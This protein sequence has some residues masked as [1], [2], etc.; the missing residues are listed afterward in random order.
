MT[1][2]IDEDGFRANVGIILCNDAG[3][4][5]LAGRAG[6]RGWQFPQGGIQPDED[7]EQAMFRELEEEVG[8]AHAD[9]SVLGTTVPWLRYR[10]PRRYLRRNSVP[11]CV[12]QK[13]IWFMLKLETDDQAVRF[14]KCDVPE[15]DRWRWVDYWQPVR[16]VI[17]F[18]RRVYSRALENL[19]PLLFA[20]G[21]PPK[22]R[23]L[24]SSSNGGRN[25]RNGRARHAASRRRKGKS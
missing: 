16:E 1:D 6:Q 22:P 2:H 15:F 7:P 5:L 17:Y 20:D 21:L 18:K 14:D 19:G 9:V 23:M 12:G 3:Q 25:K 8:L 4:L 24:Q 11:L 13:Q 10:L